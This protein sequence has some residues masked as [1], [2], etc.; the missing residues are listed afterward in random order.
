MG[1]RMHCTGAQWHQACTGTGQSLRH[2]TARRNPP[3]SS[4]TGDRC[5]SPEGGNETPANVQTSPQTFSTNYINA[6]VTIRVAREYSVYCMFITFWRYWC[7]PVCSAYRPFSLCRILEFREIVKNSSSVCKRSPESLE[8]SHIILSV[9]GRHVSSAVVLSEASLNLNLG[10]D[11]TSMV[12]LHG[13]KAVMT[14][15][16][17]TRNI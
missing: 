16:A 15:N 10:C 13:G 11:L 4:H 8:V 17:V 6:C 14:L 9:A 5:R 2:M 12:L 7:S 3:G 1:C